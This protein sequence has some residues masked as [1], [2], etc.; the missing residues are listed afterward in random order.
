MSLLL[1][2]L[3]SLMAVWDL[4]ARYPGFFA[5]AA[6]V[7]GALD[8]TKINEYLKTPIFTCNDLRDAIICATPTYNTAN[9]LLEINHDIVYKIYEICF[10]L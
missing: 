7:C 9:Y 6:P 10:I 1:L 8:P 4:I 3:C 2:V 5:A